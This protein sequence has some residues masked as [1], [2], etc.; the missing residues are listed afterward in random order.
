MFKNLLVDLN[1]T[2]FTARFSMGLPQPVGKKRKELYVKEKIFKDCLGTIMFHA[3]KL[4]AT[5]LV[6]VSDSKNVW[7][8]DIYEIYKSNKD[9]SEDVYFNDVIGAIDMLIEFISLNTSSYHISVPR[10]EGDDI[11]GYWCLNSYGVQNIIMSSDTDYI[12]LLS[13][14]TQ[15]YSP[16]QNKFRTAEDPQYELFLKC[17]RGDRSDA[18]ESAFPKV[19]ESRIK[20]AWGDDV[21]LLNFL[22][23]KRSDGRT[24]GDVIDLNM[25]IIDLS[26]QP[27][28]I[29][30]SID[31]AIVNYK[32][33]KFDEIK[34]LRFFK[35]N[36]LAAFTD[37]LRHPNIFKKS[38]I[39]R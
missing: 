37:M 12:Q 18:I 14:N 16:N 1:N 39:F 11:I 34:A 28:H 31:D 36:N 17:I 26:C 15:L 10:C 32:A 22:N 7:R 38:P 21:A 35:N 33:A 2:A 29:Q 8:K 20:S 19:R 27:M 4:G 24:V 9:P 25:Q 30:K 5:G 13:E 23:E 6:A 3:A